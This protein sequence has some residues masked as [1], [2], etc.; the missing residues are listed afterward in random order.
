MRI[1]F[2]GVRKRID[3]ILIVGIN[4]LCIKYEVGRGSEIYEMRKVYTRKMLL[5][6]WNVILIVERNAQH[7]IP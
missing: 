7:N 3:E 5:R 4:L 1:Q 6:T 2:I